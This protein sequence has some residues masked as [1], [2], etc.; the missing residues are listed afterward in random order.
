MQKRINKISKQTKKDTEEERKKINE[1][2]MEYTHMSEKDIR[3]M[4]MEKNKYYKNHH[5]IK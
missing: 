5:Q 1:I 3:D 4:V 2:P